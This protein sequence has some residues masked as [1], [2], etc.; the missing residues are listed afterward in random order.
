MAVFEVD[1]AETPMGES[2]MAPLV[3]PHPRVVWAAMLDQRAHDLQAPLYAGDL[4]A[5]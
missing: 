3:Y 1:D 5:I 2:D 4:T